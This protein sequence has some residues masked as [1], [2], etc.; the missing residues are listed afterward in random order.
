MI[1]GVRVSQG[2]SDINV[3]S[4][5]GRLGVKA[6]EELTSAISD[7]VRKATEGIILDMSAVEFVSSAGLRILLLVYK[8][9]ESMGKKVAM[10]GVRPAVYKILKMTAFEA[11]F[12][13]FD[14]EAEALEALSQSA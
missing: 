14:Q 5:A 1:A 11:M 8:E 9:A 6:Q 13:V 2:N 3:V 4:L 7:E 12:R 10:F